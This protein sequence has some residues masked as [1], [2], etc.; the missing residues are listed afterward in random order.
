MLNE[1]KFELKRE[2]YRLDLAGYNKKQILNIL[3]SRGFKKPTI[4]KY[5]NIFIENDNTNKLTPSTKTEDKY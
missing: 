2:I 4:K 5:Y 3:E 1:D